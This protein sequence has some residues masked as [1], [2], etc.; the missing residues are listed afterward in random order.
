MIGRHRLGL[1]VGCH[2][3]TVDSGTGLLLVTVDGMELETVEVPRYRRLGP[4]C[5]DRLP[6]LLE[7]VGKPYAVKERK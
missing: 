6:S 3:N 1:V 4:F 7:K 2:E 5:K